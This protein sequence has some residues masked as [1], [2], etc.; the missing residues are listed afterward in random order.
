MTT[1]DKRY[2]AYGDLNKMPFGKYKG[3]LFQDIP[4]S[5]L[6]WLYDEMKEQWKSF[7]WN[8]KYLGTATE[9]RCRVFNYIHNSLDAINMELKSNRE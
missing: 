6:R 2:P 5:Y 3:E 7:V 8:E 4:A 1:Q 9:E